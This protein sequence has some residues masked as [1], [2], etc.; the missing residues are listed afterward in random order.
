MLNKKKKIFDSFDLNQK[1]KSKF[2]FQIS[3]N[4]FEFE[5][6]FFPFF[7]V[8]DTESINRQHSEEFAIEFFIERILAYLLVFIFVIIIISRLDVSK[9]GAIILFFFF[10]Y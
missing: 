6:F 9:L 3:C 8:D 4:A 7:V 2:K 1:M 5:E 10:F